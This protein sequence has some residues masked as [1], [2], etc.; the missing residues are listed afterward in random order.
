VGDPKLSRR[1]FAVR[2]EQDGSA[3]LRD[4]GSRNGTY[5][6]GAQTVT[7]NLRDG[8]IIEA[9]DQVFAFVRQEEATFATIGGGFPRDM[10]RRR[11]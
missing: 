5:V 1:H 11:P 3:V 10:R 9:G 6:N 8:D 4:L 7:R 2:T